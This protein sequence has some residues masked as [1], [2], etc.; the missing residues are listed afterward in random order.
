VRVVQDGQEIG[1]RAQFTVGGT[2][3][4]YNRAEF[5][6]IFTGAKT[7]KDAKPSGQ[8]TL[9]ADV[10]K[11]NIQALERVS[12]RIRNAMDEREAYSE[13]VKEGGAQMLGG[14]VGM[15]SKG[16]D[17]ELKGDP[18]FPGEKERTRL[19]GLRKSLMDRVRSNPELANDIVR[20]T[21]E[22]LAKLAKRREAVADL[23]RYTDLPDGLRQQ[24][25]GVIDMHVDDMKVVRRTAQAIAMKR[26]AGERAAD[27]ATRVDQE[28]AAQ[29]RPDRKRARLAAKK[30]PV[31]DEKARSDREYARLQD[32]VSAKEARIA[33]K[34]KDVHDFSKA[35]GDAIGAKGSTAVKYGADSA[36]VQVAIAS[37]KGYIGAATDADKKQAALDPQIEK[38]RDA[39]SAAAGRDDQLSAIKALEKVLDERLKLMETCLYFIRE[40]GKA[41]FHITTRSAKSGNPAFW[42]SLGETEG[43]E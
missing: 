21:G 42:N 36:T 7:D 3:G 15:T 16:W 11:E 31:D 34:R 30:P 19:K 38:L 12:K 5:G 18:N 37:G 20:E 27:V 41:V 39:W 8:W 33:A 43:E 14:Q 26:N 1:A 28:E 35:L 25:L 40:A 10:P 4:E 17:L 29:A 6:K 32:Q 13:L 9:S 22:E 23:K 24:Q 2:S